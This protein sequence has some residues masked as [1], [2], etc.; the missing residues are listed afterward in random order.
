MIPTQRMSSNTLNQSCMS[1]CGGYGSSNNSDNNSANLSF[2][3]DYLNNAF[4]N[5]F[6]TPQGRPQPQLTFL[7]QSFNVPSRQNIMVKTNL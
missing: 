5:S 3:D 4:N 6:N 2:S 7:N 1:F